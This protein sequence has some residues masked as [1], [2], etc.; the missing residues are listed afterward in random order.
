[1]KLD[2]KGW[3]VLIIVIGAVVAGSYTLGQKN[4]G[5]GQVS[6][7]NAASMNTSRLTPMAKGPIV[8]ELPSAGVLPPGATLPSNHPPMQQDTSTQ[9]PMAMPAPAP[10]PV[11][12]N[13]M[14]RSTS[15]FTHFRV[16]NRNVKGL[17][18]DQNTAWIGTS[19]GVIRY[20]ML[21]DSHTVF[22]N[23]TSGLL[24]NGI[25]HVS[26]VDDSIVAGTYGGGLS[27][28]DMKTSLWKNYNIPDGLA[29]QFV[30][31]AQK[32][33]NG[34]FWIA[35]WSGANRI[36]GGA[37]DDASAWTTFDV[38]NTD[39]GLP[40][41]WVYALEEG[42]D[43]TM[44]FATEEGLARYKN[45]SWTNWK[46]SD[47]LGAPYE[48]VKES[49]KATNDPAKASKHHARNKA[50]QGLEDVNVAYNPNYIISL[51]VDND[52]VV[53]CGTW[54]AGLARFDGKS[55]KNFTTEDGLPANHIFML[56][57]DPEGHLWAGTNHGLAKLNDDGKSFTV[58]T[59]A[60][61][62]FANNVFSMA[63]ANDG[64]MWVGSFGGVARIAPKNN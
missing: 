7:T 4:A 9:T 52:G 50:D 48:V 62:L 53:W 36:K 13:A 47:G 43:G 27:V 3:A 60:D 12:T 15:R 31:D 37:L 11:A 32:T 2:H 35:T 39:G 38:E 56:Y 57:L 64:T 41:R 42:V 17:Y 46:H 29:D 23:K 44:W 18:L 24:S 28:F 26:R 49:I 63:H 45:D 51:K 1:V 61:G 25:F 40:N 34:D 21:D 14:V 58:M 30:Y 33:R 54:G 59:T 19:G 6:A 8:P 55:W 5:Q 10:A 20:N 22:D 16:G